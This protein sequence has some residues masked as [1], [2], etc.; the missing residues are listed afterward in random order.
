MK[1]VFKKYIIFILL[2]SASLLAEPFVNGSSEIKVKES[3]LNSNRDITI[4][5][6]H[7]ELILTNELDQ[8]DIS[9]NFEIFF[10]TYNTPELFGEFE[11]KLSSQFNLPQLKTEQ[12]FG[13]NLKV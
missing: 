3:A 12:R 8:S 1:I 10:I 7:F 11:S 5:L 2:L 13:N 9:S 4:A 6:P